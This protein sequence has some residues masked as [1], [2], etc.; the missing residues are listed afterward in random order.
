MKTVLA[1][2]ALIASTSASAQVTKAKNLEFNDAAAIAQGMIM[3]KIC[4]FPH[5]E[6]GKPAED[7]MRWSKER[8]AYG[9]PVD[10]EWLSRESKARQQTANPQAKAMMCSMINTGNRAQFIKSINSAHRSLL[11]N[12]GKA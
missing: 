10:Q 5:A 9:K 7:L 8:T 11:R 12:W 2:L 1:A 6:I 3:Y 4:G